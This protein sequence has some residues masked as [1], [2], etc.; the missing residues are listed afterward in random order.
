MAASLQFTDFWN[1]GAI[2]LVLR[3]PSPTKAT[4]SFLFS[5]ACT[6]AEK[7]PPWASPAATPAETEVFKKSRRLKLGWIMFLRVVGRIGFGRNTTMDLSDRPDQANYSSRNP[8]G[9]AIQTLHWRFQ[10]HPPRSL[11]SNMD[12]NLLNPT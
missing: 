6:S 12:G 7:K 8:A 9:F 5:L 3:L 2:W 10:P 11:T 1:A 4:P